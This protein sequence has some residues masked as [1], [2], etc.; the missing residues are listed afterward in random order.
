MRVILRADIDNLGRLGDVVDVR[1]GYARNY[2]VPQGLAMPATKANLNAFELERKKLQQKMD[3]IRFAAQ[4]LADKL[5]ATEVVIPVR[6][7]ENDKLYGSVTSTN[8]A[9][10][11]AEMG[12]EVDRRKIKLDDS[13]RSLGEYEVEIKLHP[14]VMAQVKVKVVKHGREEAQE[15]AE[16]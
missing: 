16:A 13:I 14:D 15:E 9:N 10:A 6:V 2:L 5:S 11:L 8:I 7:G 1:P 12:L 3:A 4:E